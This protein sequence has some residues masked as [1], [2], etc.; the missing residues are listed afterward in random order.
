MS[1]NTAP[2]SF[3]ITGGALPAGLALSGD[4]TISGTPTTAG[5]NGFTVTATDTLGFTVAGT[6]NIGIAEAVPVAADDSAT[7]LSEQPVSV[8]ATAND[9]GV[10]SSIAIASAPANGTALVNGLAL[11]YTPAA[12]FS[13]ED[14]FTYTASGPG[15][16]S[17]PATVTITVN[18]VPVAV[19]REV[20][21]LPATPVLVEL[22]EGATG[23]PFTD[24]TL[25]A[26]T[27]AG[28]GTATVAAVGSGYVLEYTPAADFTGVA[29][30]RFTL[31]NAHATS[32]VATITFT[33]EPRPDPTEDAEVQGLLDAQVES[34]QRFATSQIGNFQQRLQQLRNGGGSG[35]SNGIGFATDSR[36][37]EQPLQPRS[38]SGACDLA[39]GQ[40][41]LPTAPLADAG[42]TGAQDPGSRFG[43][44]TGGMV[45]SGSQDGR[46]GNADISFETDGISA[47]VDYRLNDAFAFGAGIGWGGD[48]N[49][50]GGNGSFVDGD[51]T[52]FVVYAS[53]DPEGRWFVDGLLGYQ[54]LSYDLKRYLT[55][56][57]GFV[58]G[59]RDGDQW[60]GS[61]STGADIGWKTMQFTPYARLDLARGTLD[62]YT[63]SGHPILALR[64][65]DVDL[66]TSTGNLGL[67]LQF[68]NESVH[69]RF[70]PQLRIEYQ[71]DFNGRSGGTVQYADLA[72]GP[73]FLLESSDYGNN[74]WIFGAGAQL[75]TF[76][77]WL[78]GLEYRGQVGSSGETDNGVLLKLQKDL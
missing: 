65:G 27:P 3:A 76:N 43:F 30:A 41:G 61:V 2:Y 54:R 48:E 57:G 62:G 31:T 77:N 33:V 14:S 60:F 70:V 46:D 72:S 28:S 5:D 26:L 73:L 49:E 32:A 58:R 64:Y 21:V 19:S 42:E 24:A 23:G 12:G 8:A 39:Y 1:G 44:W 56:T 6:F 63:E 55:G 15:G 34:A 7:T 20:T 53:Y 69:G 11:D 10:I 40:D 51:A 9:A 52:S 35:A 50:V 16:T 66:E 18:P 59:E 71:H 13:G 36:C 38:L 75:Q 29:L 67:H 25:V 74:R 68:F 78:I 47:G 45:R 37:L 22:T 17:A 4:G